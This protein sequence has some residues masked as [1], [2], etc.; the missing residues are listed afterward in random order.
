MLLATSA[1]ASA[2]LPT[3][4]AHAGDA[5]WNPAGDTNFNNDGN[6]TDGHG[7]ASKVPT[8]TAT[9]NA[10]DTRTITFNPIDGLTTVGGIAVTSGA[11]DHRFDTIG[12]NGFNVTFNGAGLSVGSGASLKFTNSGNSETDFNKQSTAGQAQISITSGDVFFNDRS[13]ADRRQSRRP[14]AFCE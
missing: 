4:L 1:L 6:W 10:I 5:V 3:T 2:A 12:F 14:A 13:S 8:G 11:G 7:G 9:F